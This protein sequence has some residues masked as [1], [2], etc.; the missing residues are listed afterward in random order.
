[1]QV[2]W[3]LNRIYGCCLKLFNGI[4]AEG[5]T[6]PQEEELTLQG[7]KVGPTIVTS[8]I[9]I[10]KSD[11]I[12]TGLLPGY[13]NSDFLGAVEVKLTPPGIVYLPSKQ[14]TTYS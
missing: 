7:F 9:T 4:V 12:F 14:P 1:M 3:K 13:A 8:C 10:R 11:H 2:K 6:Y 5:R